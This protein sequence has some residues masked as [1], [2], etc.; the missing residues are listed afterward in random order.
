M[1]IVGWVMPGCALSGW[2]MSGGYCPRVGN[3]RV[4]VVLVGIVLL[5]EN[6][7]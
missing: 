1:G 2:V 5:P 6:R 7:I 4:G 3:V